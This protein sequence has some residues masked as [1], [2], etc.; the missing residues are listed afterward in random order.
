MNSCILIGVFTQSSRY[1]TP[2]QGAP[3]GRVWTHGARN[4][5]L[6]SNHASGHPVRAGSDG[7]LRRGGG[8]ADPATDSRS[9]A[10]RGERAEEHRP[11]ESA[12][13]ESAVQRTK[14][15]DIPGRKR[16][17]ISARGPKRRP[18]ARSHIAIPRPG[19]LFNRG[20]RKTRTRAAHVVASTS[21]ASL[22]AATAPAHPRST[23]N[24]DS[25]MQTQ[26]SLYEDPLRTIRATQL[27]KLPLPH[28]NR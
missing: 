23:N 8:N 26:V 22:R 25:K 20:R 15:R 16:I 27:G 14:E 12:R 13:S 2:G 4:Y 6:Y 9:G 18:R 28:E 21:G 10:H 1:L 19:F 11:V 3:Q 7:H 17:R 24:I 5:A